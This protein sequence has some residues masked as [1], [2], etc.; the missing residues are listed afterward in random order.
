MLKKYQ[1]RKSGRSKDLPIILRCA[2]DVY[3]HE[4]QVPNLFVRYRVQL[5]A[6]NVLRSSATQLPRKPHTSPTPKTSPKT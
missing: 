3:F 5:I 2:I 6:V 4:D 1:G